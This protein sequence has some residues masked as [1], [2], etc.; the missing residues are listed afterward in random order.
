MKKKFV[1]GLLGVAFLIGMA[2][3]SGCSS[4][5]VAGKSTL[6]KVGTP[7]AP[8]HPV[9][10]ALLEVFEPEIEK[11]TNGKFNVEIYHS[12]QIGGE[13]QLYDFTRSGIVEATAVG[14]VM[15]SEVPMMSTPDFPFIFR[16]VE[17]ARKVYQGE[18][19]KYIAE[20]L[21]SQEPLQFLSWHPNGARVF[22][23]S[24]PINSVEDFKGLKLRMPN[25]PIHVQVAQSLGANAQIMDLG[26]VFTALE[27]NVV[28]GQDNPISTVRQEGW[29][30]VQDYIYESN[31]MVSSI[32]LLMSNEFWETLTEE[33][34][35][36]FQE[37]AD[38]TS[39]KSW[40]LYQDSLEADRK[41]LEESGLT[42]V[43]PTEEDRGKLVKAME[44]VYEVLYEKYDW[45]KDLIKRIQAVE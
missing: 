43:V 35:E 3:L 24:K 26:E 19:G 20:N 18:V 9:N 5:A 4:N 40:D 14:T 36:I 30:N 22:S 21:E 8:T 45:A 41:F 15:W 17:H 25:N 34:K 29:Y 6:V 31:H 32:E 7:F 12:G 44:P 38:V 2:A 1:K 13:K 10:V 11:K 39:D 42:Y 23:S 28:D 27:Q 33:E 16:D 37:V